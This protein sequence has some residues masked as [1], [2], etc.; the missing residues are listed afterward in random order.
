LAPEPDGTIVRVVS[1]APSPKR[2]RAEQ[3]DELSERVFIQRAHD[4]SFPA[5]SE[6]VSKLAL[7]EIE[8]NAW[9]ENERLRIYTDAKL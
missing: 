6:R 4:Q 5:A 2:G 9:Y 8:M 1:S 3:Q 7:G